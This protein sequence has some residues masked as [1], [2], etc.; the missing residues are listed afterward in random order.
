MGE[1]LR[2][3]PTSPGAIVWWRLSR[4]RPAF[5]AL[6]IL[7]ILYAVVFFAPI[8][9]P[10]GESSAERT[11]PY[12]PPVSWAWSGGPGIRVMERVGGVSRPSEA[13]LRRLAFFVRGDR[14]ELVPGLNWDRH[15]FG[16]K[17]AAGGT[18]RIFL[19]GADQFGRDVFSRL[20][21]GGRLLST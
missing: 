3:P 8:L 13:P 11:R 6:R 2:T 21:Y 1:S 14:Y 10:Y 18:D 4:N 20:L 16:L 19:M 17:P 9:A 7:G 5:W 15:L 12:E